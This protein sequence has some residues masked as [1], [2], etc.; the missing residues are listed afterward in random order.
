VFDYKN[1]HSRNVSLIKHTI[2]NQHSYFRQCVS[3]IE[4]CKATQLNK[5]PNIGYIKT[6]YAYQQLHIK[7][8]TRVRYVL[9]LSYM[10]G[11]IL[12]VLD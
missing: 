7:Q 11:Y 10:V 4:T 9:T 3:L 6:I 5:I 8:T 12:A 2:Y 1:V